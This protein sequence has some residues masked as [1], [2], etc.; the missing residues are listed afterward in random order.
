[1][2]DDITITAGTMS[3]YGVLARF[4]YRAGPARGCVQTLAAADRET[5]EVVGVLTVSMPTLNAPWRARAWPRVFYAGLTARER[6]RRVN[7]NVRTI[8]RVIV[9]PRYRAMGVA[10]R[11]VEAYLAALQSRYTE[12]VAAMGRVCPFF[13]HA[14][15]REL[16]LSTPRRDVLLGRALRRCGVEAWELADMDRAVSVARGSARLCGAVWTWA[17]TSR[18]TRPH[19]PTSED[20]EEMAPLFVH[21]GASLTSRPVVYVSG[22]RAGAVQS[23]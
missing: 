13:A 6:A 1:M 15:M 22:G 17:N 20:P 8:S 21:A 2:P 9:D 11:L 12:A 3:D 19:L 7:R 14:G 18:A 16:A 5:G 10:R 23:A 4:H